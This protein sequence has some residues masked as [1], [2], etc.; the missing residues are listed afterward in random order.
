M[1]EKQLLLNNL[2][3]YTTL[4]G[5]KGI[6]ES[7]C[8]WA[9]DYRHLN[10]YSELNHAVNIL[11]TE[12]HRKV[13]PILRKDYSKNVEFRNKIDQRGGV[14]QFATKAAQITIEILWEALLKKEPSNIPCISSFCLG[15]ISNINI[16]RDGLLSQWRGYGVDGGYAIVFN[17]FEM[18]KC[19]KKECED[20]GYNTS[21]KGKVCYECNALNKQND[22]FKHLDR[23]T[24]FAFDFY[25]YKVHKTKETKPTE[26]DVESLAHCLSRFK[27]RGFEEENEYRF[28]VFASCDGK[29]VRKSTPLEEKGKPLKEIKN[30]SR[31]GTNIPYVELFKTD[32]RLPIERIV[33]G[34]H[35]DKEKRVESLLV[36]L[37]NLGLHDI[38]VSY[39]DIPYIGLPY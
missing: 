3:H 20:F 25:S 26:D 29:T 6:L 38:K 4:E 7:K 30:R 27:H 16:Q 21:G 17:F 37:K 14:E 1:D 33:I 23:I 31:K 32:T 13:I 8:L 12:L 24:N 28:F 11:E 39:S 15:E 18:L 10:D 35:K 5:L 19:F 22:L 36:Y 34:P 2:W 9:T